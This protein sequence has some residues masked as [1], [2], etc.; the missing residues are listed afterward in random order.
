MAKTTELE[1]ILDTLASSIRSFHVATATASYTQIGKLIYE[2][3][4]TVPDFTIADLARMPDM[5]AIGMSQAKLRKLLG[6]Y[7]VSIAKFRNWPKLSIPQRKGFYRA[8]SYILQIER[9]IA[10]GTLPDRKGKRVLDEFRKQVAKIMAKAIEEQLTATTILA[11]IRDLIGSK[12]G[13]PRKGA[14]HRLRKAPDLVSS[15]ISEIKWRTSA[16]KNLVEGGDYDK[17]RINQYLQDMELVLYDI[18]DVYHQ[19]KED[20][21][22]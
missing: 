20:K 16:L 8:G 7:T 11:L 6:V 15:R 19:F 4:K 2:V 21:G 3:V 14:H 1:E 17:A 22:N 9:E 10:D 18:D 12:T 5:I 13:S